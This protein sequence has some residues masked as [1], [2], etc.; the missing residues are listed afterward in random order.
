MCASL[1]WS[2][3]RLQNWKGML[4]RPCRGVASFALSAKGSAYPNADRLPTFIP[5]IRPRRA[6]RANPPTNSRLCRAK[7]QASQKCRG[8]RIRP[9]H[10]PERSKG[11]HTRSRHHHKTRSRRDPTHTLQKPSQPMPTQSVTAPLIAAQK[12]LNHASPKLSRPPK[13]RKNAAHSVSGG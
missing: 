2:R 10:E 7:P 1:S 12:A 5:F 8:G 4:A 13:E 11:E 9:P 3:T 6:K